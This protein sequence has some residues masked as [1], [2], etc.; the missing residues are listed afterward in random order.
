MESENEIVM[1][2]AEKDGFYEANWFGGTYEEVARDNPA[3]VLRVLADKLEENDDCDT[4]NDG[5]SARAI[6]DRDFAYNIGI[7]IEDYDGNNVFT[8]SV[9]RSSGIFEMRKVDDLEK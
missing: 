2:L 6:L 7:F 9:S 3:E 5:E 8:K 4:E 1:E